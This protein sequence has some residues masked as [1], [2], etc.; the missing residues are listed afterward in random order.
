MATTDGLNVEVLVN[1][2]AE[3]AP[4]KSRDLAE[5]LDVEYEKVR[6][7]LIELERLGVVYR[8]GQTRGTRW[9]LG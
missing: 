3:D 1:T 6:A 9:W 7:T 5:K 4:V 8:T 2:L